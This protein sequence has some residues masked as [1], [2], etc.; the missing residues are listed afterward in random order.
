MLPAVTKSSYYIEQVDSAAVHIATGSMPSCDI[1]AP[2][3]PRFV[4]FTG[5][6]TSSYLKSRN[7]TL[8]HHTVVISQESSSRA[9]DVN[10]QAAIPLVKEKDVTLRVIVREKDGTIYHLT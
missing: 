7:E 6:L 5:N 2:D 4:T 8:A 9:I 10:P 3:R 1:M